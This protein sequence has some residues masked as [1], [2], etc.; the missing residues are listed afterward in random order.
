MT[1]DRA[2]RQRGVSLVESL[3][4]L[5]LLAFLSLLML[6]GVASGSLLVGGAMRRTAT[7]ET[8]EGAQAL[9]RQRI[10][11]AWPATRYDQGP[12]VADFGGDD[13]NLTFWA[14]PPE[15]GGPGPMRRYHLEIAGGDLVLSGRPGL[16]R[17]DATPEVLL[18]GV[19]RL[20]IAYLDDA[21]EWRRDWAGQARPPRL[22]RIEVEFPAGDGRWWPALLVHP[23]T[24]V[25]VDCVQ[26]EIAGRCAGR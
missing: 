1:R 4:A 5:A 20:A 26:G 7:A 19:R 3:V 18:R 2:S 14:P 23:V 24:T 12:P 21:G 10:T 13:R 22:V 15:A 8:I 16:A 11:R 25:D 9:L 6:Q 17:R